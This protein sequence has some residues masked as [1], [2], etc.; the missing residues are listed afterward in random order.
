[1]SFKRKGTRIESNNLYYDYEYRIAYNGEICLSTKNP[2]S[3]C[4]GFHSFSTKDPGNGMAFVIIETNDADCFDSMKPEQK[5]TCNSPFIWRSTPVY[6]M[7]CFYKYR[8]VHWEKENK[9]C[10]FLIECPKCEKITEH[11]KV[12]YKCQCGDN[13]CNE[14]GC[15]NQKLKFNNTDEDLPCGQ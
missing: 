10:G 14:H 12:Y 6:C 15:V 5:M 3:Y 1:M 9:H 11:N 2:E 13:Y 7:E 8:S 4:N